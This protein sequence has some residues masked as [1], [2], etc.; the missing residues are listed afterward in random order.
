[1]FKDFWPAFI[2]ALGV[3]VIGEVLDDNLVYGETPPVRPYVMGVVLDYPTRPRS[4]KAASPLTT[5]SFRESDEAAEVKATR[6]LRASRPWRNPQPGHARFACLAPIML[7][8]SVVILPTP[9]SKPTTSRYRI[10]QHHRDSWTFPPGIITRS[11]QAS[12]TGTRA[13]EVVG[14]DFWGTED[15]DIFFARGRRLQDT[16]AG[17]L[18]C[19][20]GWGKTIWA[21]QLDGKIG[22]EG[23]LG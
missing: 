21:P 19:E 17:E 11:S 2:N 14:G 7:K 23:A 13:G 1:M 5:R 4:H 22:L 10:I 12:F 16:L 6:E 15:V 8:F 20:S 9:G 3:Y 18:G